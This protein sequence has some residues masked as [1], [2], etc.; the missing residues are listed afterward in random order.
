MVCVAVVISLELRDSV[1]V[2]DG[3]AIRTLEALGRRVAHPVEP[4]QHCAIGQVK[5][6]DRILR[7]YASIGGDEIASAPLQELV[8]EGKRNVVDLGSS[9]R[10]S[11]GHECCE[12]R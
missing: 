3:Q 6:R 1:L 8:A 5:A 12:R 9:D 11:L 4:A 10:V 7:P 2:V